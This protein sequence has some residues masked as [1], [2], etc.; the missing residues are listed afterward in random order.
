MKGHVFIVLIIAF[1][2][3]HIFAQKISNQQKELEEKRLRLKNEIKQIN[4]L[5]FSNTKI[6]KNAIIQVEDIQVKLNVR[7]E[8]IKITNQQ[9]NLL[10]RRITINERNI[11]N[12][13]K[14]LDQLKDEYAKMIQKS[15]VSKSLK[16]RLMF[17]FSSESFLQAYKRIQYLKQYSRYRKK[18]GLAIGKKT[19]LLQKLNQTLIEEKGIKLK[20]IEENRQ[21]QD[22]LQKER[23][24][25]QTLIKTLKQKQSDLKKRIVKKQN[26]R[27]AIDIEIK[28]LI[29][30][31]I[32]ASNKALKNNKKNTFNLTPEAKLIATNFRANK[33]RLPWPLEKG[34]VIQGFGRQRHP[35][36]K[37]A[38]IQS[39]GVIIATEPSAQVRSVF[40]GEVMSVIMIKGT[41]PSVLIRHGNFITLYTNLSKLYVRKG[42]KVG[43][44]QIIGEVFTNKQTGET[45]LQF[46]IF[47]NINALNPKDWVYQM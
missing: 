7:S 23:V 27:K 22:K 33:G 9:A 14:E 12:Q 16:N 45:Q 36:V 46:G 24:L 2:I 1:G 29:R 41:N 26:Q 44:K 6:R 40:E 20:L 25:Q 42:E 18:Q 43:A 10:N 5:L 38:T 47:N 11:L 31:A 4:T 13:R 3:N 28:R 15:Y 37:T 35:V 17:L 34:V 21:I 32:A 30:E 19:Q 8:L 39:N